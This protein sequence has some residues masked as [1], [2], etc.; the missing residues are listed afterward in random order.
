[1]ARFGTACLVLLRRYR[2]HL[3]AEVY[4]A[5]VAASTHLGRTRE[6][7]IHPASHGKPVDSHIL[8]FGQLRARPD[9]APLIKV[10]RGLPFFLHSVAG[11]EIEVFGGLAQISF[12]RQLT[13]LDWPLC[14]LDE[15]FD[16]QIPVQTRLGRQTISAICLHFNDSSV[17]CRVSP[18]SRRIST[19]NHN[20]ECHSFV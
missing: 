11:G 10:A 2:L 18:S 7:E 16:F 13:R 4:T 3:P 19:F 17:G 6:Y 5:C 1:M 14:V 20:P 8:M 15:A 9:F 12:I